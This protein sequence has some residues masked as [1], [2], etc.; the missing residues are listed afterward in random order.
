MA[1]QILAEIGTYVE[2]QFKSAA[3]LCS[4]AAWC[5]DI[6]KVRVNESLPKERNVCRLRRRLF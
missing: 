2:K 6:M 5:R 3:R 1:Q 4:W